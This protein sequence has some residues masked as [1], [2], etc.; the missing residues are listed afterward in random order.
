MGPSF[1]HSLGGD[2]PV[3]DVVVRQRLKPATLPRDGAE[4]FNCY[5]TPAA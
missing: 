3:E 4:I 5:L 1:L 2:A